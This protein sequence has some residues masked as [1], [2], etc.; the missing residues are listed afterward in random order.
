VRV[1]KIENLPATLE[2][3][4]D[5]FERD[6]VLQATPSTSY[7]IIL[8]ALRLQTPHIIVIGGVLLHVPYRKKPRVPGRRQPL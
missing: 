4:V 2:N 8:A 3:A 1:E 5:H 7:W 6:G